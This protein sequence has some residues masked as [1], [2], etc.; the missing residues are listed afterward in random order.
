MLC[1]LVGLLAMRRSLW[2]IWNIDVVLLH[3]LLAIRRSLWKRWNIDDRLI[4]VK[5]VIF[6]GCTKLM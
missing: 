2:K 6:A 3:G 1:S 5:V 4:T